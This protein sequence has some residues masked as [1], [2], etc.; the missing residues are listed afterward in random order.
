MPENRMMIDS[1]N[2]MMMD[3]K[4]NKDYATSLGLLIIFHHHTHYTNSNPTFKSITQK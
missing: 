2:G 1:E 3:A 4:K